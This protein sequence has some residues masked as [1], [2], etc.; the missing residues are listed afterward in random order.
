MF[1]VR[2]RELRGKPK[3]HA[4]RGLASTIGGK[5]VRICGCQWDRSLT[6]DCR[7]CREPSATLTFAERA[8]FYGRME[9]VRCSCGAVHDF[10]SLSAIGTMQLEPRERLELANC[11]QCGSTLTELQRFSSSS[12]WRVV[13]KTAE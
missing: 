11:P 4:L 5:V 1:L 9:F 2:W 7:D 3:T 13:S 8:P 6:F 12:R 10:G